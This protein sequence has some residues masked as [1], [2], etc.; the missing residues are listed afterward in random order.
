M[1]READRAGC[2]L[3]EGLLRRAASVQV[4][5]RR[6]GPTSSACDCRRTP[7]RRRSPRSTELRLT[8]GRPRC[9]AWWPTADTAEVAE[10]LA[11]SE[12]T[13]KGVLA[14][15]M[16]RLEARNRC[17]AVAIVLREGLI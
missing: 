10:E 2:Q 6:V 17:H 5:A 3:P 4:H 12:S 8:A 15:L 9:C 7:R 13:I 1:I 16:T 14:K 11:Y